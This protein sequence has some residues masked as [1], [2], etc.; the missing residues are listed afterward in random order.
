MA[1]IC[2]RRISIEIWSFVKFIHFAPYFSF[3]SLGVGHFDHIAS[4]Y[5]QEC[6]FFRALLFIY[7]SVLYILWFK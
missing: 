2:Q 3:S 1:D 7:P 6:P 4:L 5:P